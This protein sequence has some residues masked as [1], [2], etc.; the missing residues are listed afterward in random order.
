[1]NPQDY[2][3]LEAWKFTAQTIN[4]MDEDNPHEYG[5]R[6]NEEREDVIGMGAN[7]VPP[8]E[9]GLGFLLDTFEKASDKCKWE[10]LLLL[11]QVSEASYRRGIRQAM[12]I[13]KMEV[14]GPLAISDEKLEQV[15]YTDANV[16]PCLISND[17][18]AAISMLRWQYGMQLN[19]LGLRHPYF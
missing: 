19:R 17:S 9:V 14:P 6:F 7:D 16:S 12:A 1:M 13:Q 18:V 3:K 5:G 4:R 10:L 15:R 11:S 8:H 2:T